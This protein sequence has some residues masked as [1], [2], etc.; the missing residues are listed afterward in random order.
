MEEKENASNFVK[1]RD[2]NEPICF[3]WNKKEGKFTI[4]KSEK[5]CWYSDDGAFS[6][7]EL[8]M[9]IEPWLTCIKKT[10]R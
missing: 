3:S 9:R 5:S 8:R 1:V 2:D 6:K 4:G 10:T 7:H